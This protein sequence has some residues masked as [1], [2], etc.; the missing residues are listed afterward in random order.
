MLLSVLSY[1][2][3][4]NQNSSL[5]FDFSM[6]FISINNDSVLFKI[7]FYLSLLSD[8]FQHLS[9]K[10]SISLE[11]PF[12][13]RANPSRIISIAQFAYKVLQQKCKLDKFS[14]DY[15]LDAFIWILV[16]CNN[17][18]E[19]IDLKLICGGFKQEI[20]ALELVSSAFPKSLQ[21]EL[22]VK[23]A[24][25]ILESPVL[26]EIHMK[27]VCC[28]LYYYYLTAEARHYFF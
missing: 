22:F 7:P 18:R 3:V 16:C 8:H 13:F 21:Y 23:F 4:L 27:E 28:L 25:Y 14:N 6:Q 15:Q 2:L 11:V 5:V 24:R 12:Y 26:N 10:N 1:L 17:L 20:A 19:A 9:S